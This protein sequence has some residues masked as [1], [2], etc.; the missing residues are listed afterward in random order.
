MKNPAAIIA[1]GA[2]L[3]QLRVMRNMTQE[4]LANEAGI[5]RP[6]LQVI[7]YGK[8]SPTLD[9]LV[10]LGIALRLPIPELL[11]IPEFTQLPAEPPA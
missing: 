6:M 8:N 9:V 5:S 4:A 7:E 11:N 10:S 1:F 3:R 2:H